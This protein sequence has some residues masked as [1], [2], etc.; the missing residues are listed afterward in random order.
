MVYLLLI[1]LSP[2]VASLWALYSSKKAGYVSLFGGTLSLLASSLLFF[3]VSNGY[4]AAWE[5]SGLPGLPFRL[6]ITYLNTSLSLVVAIVGG[7]I[8][9]YAVGYMAEEKGK[10]RFWS[11][12]SLFLASMQLLLF[13]GDWILFVIA[14][15]ILGFCSYLLISTKYWQTEAGE[16]ANK[17][18]ILNRFAD[19]G[20]Y[21]GVF[22]IILSS[23]SSAIVE[24]APATI[25]QFGALSLLFGVMGKSA[26]VPFQSWLTAAMKGPTPVSALLHSAT[27]VAAG[28]VL[29]I[30]AFPLFSPDMPF[31]VGAIGGITVLMTGLTA[32]FS[33]D[34]KK[35]LAASTSSQLGFM[36]LAIGAGSTGAALAHLLAHAFMK[37]SLFLGAGIWQHGAGSTRFEKLAGAGRKLKITF[38]GFAISAVA[39]AGIPPFIGYFS[40]D[41]ILAAGLESSLPE[42]YFVVALLGSLLTAIYMS[43]TLGILWKGDVTDGIEKPR[44][45]R[46]MQSGLILMVLLVVGGGLFLHSMIETA[47]FHLPKAKIAQ[48]SGLVAALAGLTVGWLASFQKIGHPITAYL[49]NNYPIGGGYHALVVTPVIKLAALC[50]R[51]DERLHQFVLKIGQSVLKLSSVVDT[52]D[53]RV[54]ESV[55]GVGRIGLT[56]GDWSERSDEQGING[57]IFKIVESVKKMGRQGQQTQSGLV[58]RELMWSVWGMVAFLMLMILTLM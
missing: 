58:H 35:M 25:S 52:T 6:D 17:A 29:L 14:W 54:H 24:S 18:F 28:I 8:L 27:M 13:A 5:F 23:G 16:A 46:W 33:N 11:S 7:L 26:Q 30:K 32:I 53:E 34:I 49:R 47:G 1:L 50:R 10:A 45:L 56:L 39:L 44:G 31:W 41:G 21:I 42:W 15:E 12:I 2:A 38:T 19:L 22:V 36:I 9:L 3:K 37:S 20:L 55:H 43:R 40:K 4:S 57:L 48:I 51:L